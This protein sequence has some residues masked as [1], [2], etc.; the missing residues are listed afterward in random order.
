M[1]VK[2]GIRMQDLNYKKELREV[3]NFELSI[4]ELIDYK[5]ILICIY[6]SS[7]GKFVVFLNKLELI[8][9]E[10]SNKNKRLILSGDWN[11]NFLQDGLHVREINNVLIRYNLTNTVKVP[12]RITKTSSSLLDVIIIHEEKLIEPA[13]VIELGMSDHYAQTL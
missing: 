11:I 6:R 2:K 8:I 7:A 5:V 1:Y 12:T 13:R 3:K 9:Q 4:T 10:L